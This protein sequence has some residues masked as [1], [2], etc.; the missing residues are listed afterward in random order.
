MQFPNKFPLLIDGQLVETIEAIDVID[1]ATELVIATCARTTPALVDKAVAAAKRAFP[2][3]R[4]TPFDE[5]RLVVLSI[6]DAIERHS[7]EL[8]RLIVGEQGK[9]SAVATIEIQWAIEFCRY[10]ASLSLAPEVLQDDAQQRVELHHRPIGVVAGLVPWNFPFLMAVYKLAP[11]LM[12]GNTFVLKPSPTTPL[13]ALRLGEII[14]VLVPRGV[15]NIVSDAGDIGPILTAHPD[16]AKV[17]F[18]GSSATG[19]SVM[20]AAAPTLKRLTLELGGNDAAIV[21]EDV[22]V[23]ATAQ[24]VFAMAFLNSG[25]VC[26]SIK[27]IYVQSTIYDAMCDELARLAEGTKI[28]HGLDPSTQLGPLQNQ[29]QFNAVKQVLEELPRHGKVIAGGTT[30]QPGFFI[31]PT[32]VRDIVE[33]NS[34]VDQE[35]FGPVRSILKFDSIDEA[36]ARANS[37]QYGLGASVWTK[38]LARGATIAARLEAGSAWV[39]QHCA[40]APHIP[41]GGVKQSGLGREFSRDGLLEYTT[42]QSLVVSK[43]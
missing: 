22:D 17:S 20:A 18:T 40:I 19:R 21:L 29:R 26:M 28:G 25:Q 24:K 4:D 27:R 33:G 43:V 41:I 2:A 32:L 15:V 9:P 1:P 36:V 30:Q 35:I 11:A 3:W 6:S 23:K 16:V 13:S 39:N 34:V 5:R 8:I 14:Q 31:R 42:S 37:S 7:D 10:F 38:D 12:T